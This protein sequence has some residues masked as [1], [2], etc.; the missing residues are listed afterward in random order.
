MPTKKELEEFVDTIPDTPV[1]K[2][3]AINNT[4]FK[5]KSLTETME[6]MNEFMLDLARN[7]PD[8]LDALKHCKTDEEINK[9]TGD[10]FAKNPKMIE[11][12]LLS[13]VAAERNEDERNK[14]KTNA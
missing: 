10:F 4:F 6:L 8:Y 3:Q 5:G 14:E 9:A 11:E 7:N 2:L 1:G 12:V 13:L